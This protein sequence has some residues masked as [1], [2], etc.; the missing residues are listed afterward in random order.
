MDIVRRNQ[1][2]SGLPAHAQ[3]SRIDHFLLRNAV[4]LQLQEKI[5]PAKTFLVLI[6]HLLRFLVKSADQTAL[7]LPRK[8]GA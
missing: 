5:S 7:H 1:T 2:D 4:I 6:R 3:K 8:T